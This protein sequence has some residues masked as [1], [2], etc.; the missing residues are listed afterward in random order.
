MSPLKTLVVMTHL[1]SNIGHAAIHISIE[2]Q[3]A[4]RADESGVDGQEG[5][6][7]CVVVEVLSTHV[8]SFYLLHGC[9]MNCLSH[10]H[11]C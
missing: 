5:G 1:I 2:D 10:L 9:Y 7:I 8:P 3:R 4:V 6:C 11:A